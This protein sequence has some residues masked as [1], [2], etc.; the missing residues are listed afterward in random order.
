[1]G[2]CNTVFV[3]SVRHAF[4][5][6]NTSGESGVNLTTGLDK[7]LPR[8]A[9]GTAQY[10][11]LYIVGPC[12]I[13]PTV[14][15]QL[16][17]SF[18]YSSSSFLSGLVQRFVIFQRD[19]KGY[20]LTV[21]GDNPVFVQSIKKGMLSSVRP[22]TFYKNNLICRNMCVTLVGGAAYCAGV[23]KGDRIIKVSE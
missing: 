3:M 2:P 7:W 17:L 22:S 1:M 12:L 20:G 9:I 15:N 16:A 10:S 5:G 14:N 21:S 19:E 8:C 18:N 11:Q 23:Q 4:D 13:E 6:L